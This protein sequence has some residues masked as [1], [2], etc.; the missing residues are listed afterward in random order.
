M[1]NIKFNLIVLID[2]Y[3][4]ILQMFRIVYIFCVQICL[5]SNANEYENKY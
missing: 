4:Y 5:F 2:L 3:R 1:E